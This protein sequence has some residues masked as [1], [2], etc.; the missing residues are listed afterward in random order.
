M[1]LIWSC[2]W[3]DVKTALNCRMSS[4]NSKT[5]TLLHR[6][7]LHQINSW[8]FS[9]CKVSASKPY[10]HSKRRRHTNSLTHKLSMPPFVPGFVPGT[11]WVCP[12]DKPGFAGLPLCKI[13]RKPGFVPGFTGLV[14]G[15]NPVKSP[16]QTRG[17]PKTNRTKKFMFMCL[18]LA[19]H[20]WNCCNFYNVC[21]GC[22]PNGTLKNIL[23]EPHIHT[24]YKTNTK[25]SDF[26]FLFPYLCLY[27]GFW[28]CILGRAFG[29]RGVL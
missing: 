7:L 10:G 27:L 24:R 26:R 17:R 3:G 9:W 20:Q 6:T 13:R 4:R 14:A 18:F 22:G 11:N 8:Q 21:N 1:L 19:W 29:F 2:T 15:T 25:T 23:L 5:C 28:K 12:W 16:G